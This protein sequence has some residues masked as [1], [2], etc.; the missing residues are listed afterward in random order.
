VINDNIDYI[1][2]LIKNTLIKSYNRPSIYINVNARN[3]KGIGEW[4]KALRLCKELYD[5]KESEFTQKGIIKKSNKNTKNIKWFY[6]TI[7]EAE[8]AIK[9]INTE[10]FQLNDKM[11]TETSIQCIHKAAKIL[12]T[13]D[14]LSETCLVNSNEKKKFL[15]TIFRKPVFKIERRLMTL[16]SIEENEAFQSF[17]YIRNTL[18]FL[19]L[20]KLSHDI[21]FNLEKRI[22]S[23]IEKCKYF[24][25]QAESV[26]LPKKQEFMN[27]FFKNHPSI[28]SPVSNIIN[29]KEVLES[30]QSD[31][32]EFY[33]YIKQI[34]LYNIEAKLYYLQNHKG[35]IYYLDKYIIDPLLESLKN[36]I[37]WPRFKDHHT[38]F[39]H[40]LSEIPDQNVDLIFDQCEQ[41]IHKLECLKP[42]KSI[43]HAQLETIWKQYQ[44]FYEIIPKI[45]VMYQQ[46]Y[47]IIEAYLQ[48]D[49]EIQRLQNIHSIYIDFDIQTF[50]NQIHAL[51]KE[52]NLIQYD[53]DFLIQCELLLNLRNIH[54]HFNYLSDELQNFHKNFRKQLESKYLAN[55]LNFFPVGYIKGYYEILKTDVQP[56]LMSFD[57]F[58]FRSVVKSFQVKKR[59]ESILTT[60][61]YN[62]FRE[63]RFS[64]LSIFYVSSYRIEEKEVHDYIT[65]K[66]ALL[67]EKEPSIISILQLQ[68][69]CHQSM[70]K[71]FYHWI[72]Q[73]YIFCYELHMISKPYIKDGKY[74]K[75][76]I[77]PPEKL[78]DSFFKIMKGLIGLNN[79]LNKSDQFLLEP[80][81]DNSFKEIGNT[82]D[83]FICDQPNE[84]AEVI[85]TFLQAYQESK[86]EL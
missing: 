54:I 84:L 39:K 5:S 72:N 44:N 85:F 13:T 74:R 63:S 50:S 35:L 41:Y 16:L 28:F 60:F 34:E 73:F 49:E 19:N 46:C 45:D 48:N 81:I 40:Q 62:N 25:S 58:D 83:I 15:Y 51:S 21:E 6:S 69:P 23:I 12:T 14:R 7:R 59:Y 3:L 47:N 30:F 37:K 11:Y 43:P 22:S 70:C 36:F 67:E 17:S 61:Q 86:S 33:E 55:N 42:H 32:P 64:Y 10:H 31:Y 52:L 24:I 9:A 38:T 2:D 65:Q 8:R 76:S 29:N 71:A 57:K 77:F 75:E 56:M 53:Q 80:Y 18:M 4:I 26:Q 20:S 68:K 27:N 82:K 1:F 66:K 79:V 78:S